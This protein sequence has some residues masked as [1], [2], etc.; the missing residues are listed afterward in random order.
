MPLPRFRFNIK[1][2]MI[3]VAAAACA[4]AIYRSSNIGIT[5]MVMWMPFSM[6]AERFL[7]DPPRTAARPSARRMALN[8]GVMGLCASLAALADWIGCNQW[9]PSKIL[10]P[11]PLFGITPR[12]IVSS[13]W[14]KWN[15]ESIEW[16]FEIIPFD[17]MFTIILTIIP[18]TTFFVLNFYLGRTVGPT[19]V[20]LRF[21]IMLA[22]ATGFSADWIIENWQGG[23]DHQGIVYT[24]TIAALNLGVVIILWGLWFA[25]RRNAPKPAALTLAT[26][27]HCWIFWIAFPWMGMTF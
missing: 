9:S 23:I 8:Y 14:A 4:L 2:M 7:A 19:P 16:V 5:I 10:S 18:F 22:I 21:P 27:F 11:D 25:I 20:P 12:M 6:I 1:L 24:H 13:E 17:L 26:L 15:L 3:T